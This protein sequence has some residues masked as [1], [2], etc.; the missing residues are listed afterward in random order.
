MLLLQNVNNK[1]ILI[2]KIFKFKINNY[3]F[4]IIILY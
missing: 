2:Y 1:F 4:A 3:Q